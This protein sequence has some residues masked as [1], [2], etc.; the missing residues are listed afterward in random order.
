MQR[1]DTYVAV[2]GQFSS[3]I[4]PNL[5]DLT[6]PDCC[7]HQAIICAGQANSTYSLFTALSMST[8]LPYSKYE[9]MTS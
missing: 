6:F 9:N 5:F 8:I 7:Q 3:L 2:G 1:V 4:G